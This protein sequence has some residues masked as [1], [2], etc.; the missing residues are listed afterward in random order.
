MTRRKTPH[1]RARNTLGRPY[2]TKRNAITGGNNLESKH[3]LDRRT[4]GSC[5]TTGG[6]TCGNRPVDPGIIIRDSSGDIC[7]RRYPPIDPRTDIKPF[8]IDFGDLEDSA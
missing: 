8:V 3:G 7:S 5:D 2:R 6:T 1:P 4:S